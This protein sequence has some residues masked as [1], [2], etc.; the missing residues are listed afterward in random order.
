MEN[1]ID[2]HHDIVFF[3]VVIIAFTSWML[4]RIIYFFKFKP[5]FFFNRAFFIKRFLFLTHNARLEII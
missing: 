5:F 4:I 3:L 1:I 2:L